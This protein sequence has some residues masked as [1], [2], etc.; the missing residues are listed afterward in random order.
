[1]GDWLAQAF[2]LLGEV[3]YGGDNVWDWGGLEPWAEC[4]PRID[5]HWREHDA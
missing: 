1:M 2:E 4:S 5:A 3:R